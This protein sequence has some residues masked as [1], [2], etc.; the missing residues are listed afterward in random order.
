MRPCFGFDV[1]S[2]L[3]IIDLNSS[4]VC[5][6]EI[7]WRPSG[8]PPSKEALEELEDDPKLN[9][10]VTKNALILALNTLSRIQSDAWLSINFPTKYIGNGARFF[11]S[12]SKFIQGI[13]NSADFT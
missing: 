9:V 6:G 2:Q 3:E 12:V 11:K 5:G 7:L 8:S 4:R 13:I 1:N 10:D